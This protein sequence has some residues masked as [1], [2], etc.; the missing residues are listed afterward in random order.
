MNAATVSTR[1][2][3]PPQP[4]APQSQQSQPPQSQTLALLERIASKVEANGKLLASLQSMTAGDFKDLRVL[5]AAVEAQ[6]TNLNGMVQAMRDNRLS[7]Q[8]TVA[9]NDKQAANGRGADNYKDFLAEKLIVG[10]SEKTGE[11]TC[12]LQGFPYIKFGVPVYPEV[13]PTLGIDPNQLTPGRPRPFNRR[14]RAQLDD[15]GN[16]KRII[17]FA[18]EP[19]NGNRTAS[20]TPPD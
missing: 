12:R 6:V 3:V 7:S 5:I 8:D 9:D 19:A 2:T 4:R 14:V 11:V 13:L 17:G 18:L 15:K 20:D 10:I 16:P 1:A